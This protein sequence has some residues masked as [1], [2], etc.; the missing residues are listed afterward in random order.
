MA[1]WSSAV[2]DLLCYLEAIDFPTPRLID[3]DGAVE[4]LAWIEGTSG[5]EGF[6]RVVPESGLRRWSHCL[7]VFHDVVADYRP[8][9]S[10]V[11]SSGTG[12]RS[13]G[14]VVRHG[15]F[16]PWNGVWQGDNIVGLID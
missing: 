16:G 2:H 6:A 4:V 15:D 1:F 3:E 14:E 12:T 7:R 5:P 10:S 9:T 13:P 11:W 8:L